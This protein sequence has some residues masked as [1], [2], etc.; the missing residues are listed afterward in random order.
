MIGDVASAGRGWARRFC[1]RGSAVHAARGQREG[2]HAMS[3]AQCLGERSPTPHGRRRW[4]GGRW[5]GGTGALAGVV[6]AARAPATVFEKG[7]KA[8]R[9][10][11]ASPVLFFVLHTCAMPPTDRERRHCAHCTHSRLTPHTPACSR[12]RHKAQG[13]GY[14]HPPGNASLNEPADALSALR[15]PP[16]HAER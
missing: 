11:P 6:C 15:D 14:R 2:A 1:S 16:V 12:F 9:R 8:S 10:R 5:G 3:L 7:V 4:T 13:T